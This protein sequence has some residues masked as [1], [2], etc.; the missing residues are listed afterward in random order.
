MKGPRDADLE[1]VMQQSRAFQTALPAAKVILIPDTD[2]F[3]FFSNEA[4]VLKD[5]NSFIAALPR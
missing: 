5:I 2:H 1:R 3:V 4:E